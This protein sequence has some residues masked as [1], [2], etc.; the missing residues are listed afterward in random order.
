MAA[1]AV[2][3]T[4]TVEFAT[5]SESLPT[6]E[7]ATAVAVRV[8]TS[9]IA[10]VAVIAAYASV[11]VVMIP[12]ASVTAVPEIRWMSPVIPRPSTDKYSIYEIVRSVIAIRRT[13]IWI[14]VIISVRADGWPCH[15]S[16]SYTY[17]DSNSDLRLRISNRQHQHRQ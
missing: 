4:A 5:A 11:E 7:S 16:G 1:S 13:S 6:M 9:N 15:K 17:P 10:A 12:T 8:A 2:D 3:L 14:V